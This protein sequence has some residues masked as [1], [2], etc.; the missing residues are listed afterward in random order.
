MAITEEL[1]RARGKVSKSV[2]RK[3]RGRISTKISHLHD[4]GKP[5]KQSVAI[6]LSMAKE[7][8]L[9]PRGGYQRK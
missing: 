8:R 2:Q 4:E 6:A 1:A 5:R 3:Q 7:G 9:G